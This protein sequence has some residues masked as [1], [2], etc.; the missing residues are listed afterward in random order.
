MLYEAS[1]A[2]SDDW[3]LIRLCNKLGEGLP[4]MHR[5]TQYRNGD[6]LIPLDLTAGERESYVRFMRRARL[7]V[8]ET[9]RDARTNRQK[10][11]GFRTAVAGDEAGDPEAWANWT[12]SRMPVKSRKHFNDKADYGR[13]YLL[14]VREANGRPVYQQRD[15]W[16]TVTIQQTTTDWLAEAGLT[17]GFDPILEAEVAILYRPG[18]YRMAYRRTS[19][20]TLPRDG[21][22]W[23]GT[24]D[25]TWAGDAIRTPWTP[26]CLLTVDATQDGYGI[27]EK[28][29]DTVDRINEITLNALSIIVQQAFQQR[30]I[31][32]RLPERYPEGHERAGESIDY[33]EMFKAGPAAL[34]LLGDAKI[35]QLAATD[36][37]PV[38]EARKHEIEALASL[39]ATPQYVFQGDSANQSGNS[40]DLAREQVVAAVEAMND[41][42]AG[43]FA[44]VQSLG[45][46]ARGDRVRADVTQIEVMFK[47]PNPASLPDRAKAAADAKKGGATQRWIDE[48]AFEM[49]PG[50]L[51]QAEQDRITEAFIDTIS[52]GTG[53]NDTGSN[54]SNR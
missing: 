48:N 7:H 41:E 8:V 39:T 9:L 34:W 10:V 42:S 33:E 32:G 45:F 30:A 16:D 4:R 44:Q 20:P 46:Q 5:I 26:D 24:T 47:K 22:V 36:V 3:Y 28:H 29:L 19:V 12:G 40:A 2:G 37:R 35:Q 21:T 54:P 15:G 52:G 50:E 31:E 25:W 53:G 51:R 23:Y 27:Y 14:T 11:I 49:T 6:A 18:Y 1:I 13:S 43:A 17:V 38:Y